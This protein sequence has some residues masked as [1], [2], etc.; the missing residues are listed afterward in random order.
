MPTHPQNLQSKIYPAWKKCRMEQR[1]NKRPTT[2][3]T[4]TR[5]MGKQQSL[6][7]LWF[8][9]AGRLPSITVFWVPQHSSGLNRSR[10]PQPNTRRRSAARMGELEGRIEGLEVD[11]THR[12]TN[13][14]NKPRPWGALRIWAANQRHTLAGIRT[15]WHIC[16]RQEAQSSWLLCPASVGEGALNLT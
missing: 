16:S 6:T 11:G 3:P 2:C 7:L 8:S 1:P 9:Y 4:W 13:R 14:A 15:L 10:Y 12:R 5:P